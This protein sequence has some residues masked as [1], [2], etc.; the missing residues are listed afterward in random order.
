MSSMKIHTLFK[1]G[2]REDAIV[3]NRNRHTDRTRDAMEGLLHAA[4]RV[5]RSVL[6]G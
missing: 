5:G 2:C 3:E 4:P 6:M 1:W